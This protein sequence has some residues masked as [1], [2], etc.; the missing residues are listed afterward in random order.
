M[1]LARVGEHHNTPEY[2]SFGADA[3]TVLCL[4]PDMNFFAAQ[5]DEMVKLHDLG[6]MVLCATPTKS[7]GLLHGK[8]ELTPTTRLGEHQGAS[9]PVFGV[10]DMV[11][12]DFGHTGDKKP[13]ANGRRLI[14]LCWGPESKVV[15]KVISEQN[16]LCDSFI[17]G[18]NRCPNALV[19]FVEEAVSES[20]GGK[21]RR[22]P[23]NVLALSLRPSCV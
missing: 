13:P 17:L 16:L 23:P 6:R 21:N 11:K 20:A 7:F 10:N 19:T 12:I 8:M 2:S 5:M 14:V 4:P 22:C 1:W 18:W 9:S 15:A 3:N